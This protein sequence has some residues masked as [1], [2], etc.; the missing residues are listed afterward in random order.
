ML[1]IERMPGASVVIGDNIRIQVLSV[2]KGARVKLGIDAPRSIDINREELLSES[3]PARPPA[4]VDRHVR[5]V[6][7][8]GPNGDA[9]AAALR[10]SG[11]SAVVICE[12]GADLLAELK[13]GGAPD[14]VL[15]AM[16]L[17][18]MSGL[19]ALRTLR[20]MTGT[21]STP[22][23]MMVND[24]AAATDRGMMR[25]LDAGASAFVRADR[26]D[27]ALAESLTRI[28]EFWLQ[29]DAAA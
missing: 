1:A 26:G 6:F 9:A 29:R 2:R 21:R 18:D 28:A 8:V 25:C 22:I 20:S 19:T 15:L 7:V 12:T 17:P 4:A 23:V 13:D 11:A 3:A 10:S 16:Q 24:A 5:R 14:L 27:D